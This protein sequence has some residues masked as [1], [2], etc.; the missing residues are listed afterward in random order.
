[1]A[2]VKSTLTSGLVSAFKKQLGIS[3]GD[4]KVPH[5]TDALAAD[6]GSAYDSY[7]SAGTV[8][9]TPAVG[10][11]GA[12]VVTSALLGADYFDG[13]EKGLTDYWTPATF[14][15]GTFVS[16]ASTIVAG[17]SG[18]KAAVRALLPDPA[19]DLSQ[20]PEQ[21]LEDFCSKL[22]DALDAHTTAVTSILTDQS[23]GTPAPPA[24]VA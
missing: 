18:C 14:G 13:W 5:I 1:M 9:M 17:I 8:T 10:V 7:A 19:G 23:S 15:G 6:L 2:L 4:V 20:S 3:S 11:G 24:P 21:T 22:A 12:S 16:G